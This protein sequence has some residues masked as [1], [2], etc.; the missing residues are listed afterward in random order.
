MAK[1]LDKRNRIFNIYTK[2]LKL[3]NSN[4]LLPKNF[5]FKEEVYWC[6]ICLSEFTEEDLAPESVNMLTL[7]DAPPKSLGGKANTLTCKSCNSKCGHEIDF[8]LNDRLIELDVRSFKPNVESK[9]KLSS[10]GLKVQGTVKVDDSSN[11]SIIHCKRN[12][13]PDTL[14]KYINSIRKNDIVEIE[15][16][17]SRVEK[18]RLEVALLKSAYILAFGKYGYALIL[19]KSFDIV[20][21]QL[22]NPEKQI[23]PEGFWTKQNFKAEHEGVHVIKSQDYEGFFAVFKL[24]TNV[25]E[26]R[27]GVYLPIAEE[28]T[29]TVIDRLKKIEGG[30][31]LEMESNFS[32]DYFNEVENMKL[33]SNYINSKNANNY[34]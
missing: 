4:E 2:Q 32:S 15:F 28:K 29:K 21:E 30:L 9:V 8:H 16:K 10:K 24:K 23:Y 3:L 7:E 31:K 5:K 33:I 6:P 13:N 19:N 12:N 20:R 1:G 17:Q 22:L 34:L 11:I 18:L 14:N 27:F 25:I 26:H